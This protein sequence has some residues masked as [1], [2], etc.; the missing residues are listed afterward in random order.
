MSLRPPV[1]RRPHPLPDAAPPLGGTATEA[2]DAVAVDEDAGS[3]EAVGAGEIV[4]SDEAEA[5]AVGGAVLDRLEI[6]ANGYT[7]TGRAAGP[8]D[9]R[10]VL[11]LHG[12]PQTSWSWR[13]VLRALGDAG[14][15]AVAPDQR[16]YAVGARP[17]TIED[18][19]LEHLVGDVLALADAMEMDSFDLVGHDWGGLLSWILA[20]RHPD[21]VRSLCVVST[22]HPLAL[23]EQ[24]ESASHME[25]F[26][27]TD[28]PERLLLG[29]D[30]SGSGLRAQFAATGLNDVDAEEYL[31]VLT[32]PGALTA[33]LH[34][35]R[36]TLGSDLTDLEPIA[37]PTLYVW[38]SGDTALGRTAA[39]ASA[40]HVIGLYQFTVLDGVSHWIPEAAPNELSALLLGHLAAT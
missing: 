34:W 6:N 32:Q 30:G 15:R 8:A 35:Y 25:V 2:G 37:V 13:A 16:G 7:F 29:A 21:R 22:P 33:A 27:Q 23:R 10:R 1:L 19:A 39:E 26:R 9:G 4:R 36:A 11:L 12:F 28:V 31:S 24:V 38:S 17:E 5:V 14:Y 3:S 40:A 18:Y 20:A